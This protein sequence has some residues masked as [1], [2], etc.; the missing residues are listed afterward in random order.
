MAGPI[1]R[2]DVRMI[3]FPRPDKARPVVVLTR[4]SATQFLNRIVVAPIT[5]TIRG[6][7]TEVALGEE[8]GMKGTCAVNLDHVVSVPRP[9]LGR[10]LSSLSAERMAAICQALEF[11]V[12]CNA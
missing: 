12:G 11:A 3:R 2:G 6:V 9:V 4:S 10:R 7:P 8:D 5:S 1:E